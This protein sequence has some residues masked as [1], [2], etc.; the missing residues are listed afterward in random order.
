MWKQWEM[1]MKSLTSI[2]G[3]PSWSNNKTYTTSK[4][5]RKQQQIY[6]IFIFKSFDCNV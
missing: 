6:F 4:V 5:R 3:V 1:K 2:L